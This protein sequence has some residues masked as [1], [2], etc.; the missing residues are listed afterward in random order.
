MHTPKKP[1]PQLDPKVVTCKLERF[2]SNNEATLSKFFIQN[3]F[4]CYIVEDQFAT[5]KLWGEMRIPEGT[6]DISY[7]Y[8]GRFH[9]RYKSKFADFHKGILCVHNAPDWKIIVGDIV[10][11]YVLIH[12]GNTDDDT[13]G[14]LLPNTSVD[15]QT[16]RGYNSTDA[17]EKLYKEIAKYLDKGLTVKLIVEDNDRQ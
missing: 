4:I 17:Y 5:K 3:K 9:T 7:R 16:M 15:S 1:L 6:F 2:I 11:Q 10:F 13:A 12:L 8:E 14:C